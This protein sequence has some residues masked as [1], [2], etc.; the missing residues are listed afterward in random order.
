[1][2]A[3]TMLTAA[4][5]SDFSDYN[6]VPVD[7][8]A[9]G[10]QT[11]WE[12]ISQ[13]PQ[14]TEFAAL[15]KRV[16]F[17]SEL[18]KSGFYTVWA[19]LNGTFSAADYAAMSDSLVLQQFVK[20][21]VAEY[22]HGASGLVRERIHTL[23][24]KSY[25]FE[26]NGSYT[27]DR[28]S[29]TDPN[30]P[31]SNGVLHLLGGQAVFYP[32]LYEYLMSA[33]NNAL[34]HD[35]FKKYEQTYLD[36]NASVKG[37]M[38]DGVQTYIDSVMVTYNSLTYSLNALIQNE[39][40]S[41]TFIMPTDEAYQKMY[42]RVKPLHNYIESTIV[43]DVEN[44]TSA[45]G[46]Q[47]KTITTNA[48]YLQD[49]LTSRAVVRNL[50]YS[51]NDAYN[52]WIL[53][54]GPETDT[55]RSTTRT[56]LSNPDDILNKYMVGK[57]IE[58]S[59][60]YARL[61]DSL[62]FY[63]WETFNRQINVNPRFYLYGL[64]DGT[65]HGYTVEDSFIPFVFGPDANITDFRYYSI[66]PNGIYNKPT[67]II[68]LPD[69]L[70]TTYNF[71]VVFLPSAWSVFG[72]EER[73]NKLNFQ[74][75]YCGTNGKLANYIFDK[76]Y[77]DSLLTGGKLPTLPTSISS[78]TVAMRSAFEND[79]FKTDTV[80]I[81]RFTFPVAYSGLGDDYRPNIRITS[82]ISTFNATQMAQ[83]TRDV[84]IAAIIMKPVELEEFENNK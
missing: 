52:Q 31:S 29:I 10:N 75:S 42:D 61:V 49:S 6:E 15:V 13:H 53:G 66:E 56:K 34:L 19:P 44:F 71:Y 50:I 65:A 7:Q 82:P 30:L 14:L 8:L 5:C 3:A 68:S 33:E 67:I 38:V 83:Y 32:N 11:L 2:L 41:Y 40:S 84:R 64:F 57:P 22:G 47:T 20:N 46:T 9:T 54:N 21:H 23:N 39:D 1:M 48:P 51:N 70:S 79:P 73:P 27:F 43:Q 76:A 55:L 35:Y 36:Q 59:N 24:D 25:I 78:S 60:G 58:L 80:F 26:G 63:P 16:G 62:A 45:S 77:A 17:D 69:V 72:G 74:L 81:G 4:S 18:S 37:P 12:N 28:V